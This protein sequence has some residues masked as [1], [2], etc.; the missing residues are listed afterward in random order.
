[1]IEIRCKLLVSD[2]NTEEDLEMYQRMGLPTPK[3]ETGFTT[4]DFVFEP[5]AATEFYRSIR[6]PGFIAVTLNGEINHIQYDFEKFIRIR[7]KSIRQN[8]ESYKLINK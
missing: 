1:M 5:A 7:A 4:T 3:K 8:I 2:P 6:Y